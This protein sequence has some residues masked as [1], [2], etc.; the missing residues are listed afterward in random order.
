[1]KSYFEQDRREKGRTAKRKMKRTRGKSKAKRDRK[2]ERGKFKKKTEKKLKKRNGGIT[3][4]AEI[5]QRK[6]NQKRKDP[7]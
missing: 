7:R 2:G 6:K 5:G 1:M 4:E 3:I